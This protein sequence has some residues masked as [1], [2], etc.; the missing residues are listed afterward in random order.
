MRIRPPLLAALTALATAIGSAA[1]YLYLNDWFGVGDLRAM[2]VWSMPVAAG[3]YLASHLA[4]R[5]SNTGFRYLAAVLLGLGIGLVWDVGA[6]AV[7]GGW[8]F[9]FSFPVFFCWIAASMVGLIVAVWAES[10]RTWAVAVAL[11]ALTG[12]GTARS[13]RHAQEPPPRVVVYLKPGITEAE[14]ATVW[15]DVLG[16]SHPGRIGH[17]LKEPIASVLRDVRS[18]EVVLVV[19]FW[20]GHAAARNR[21]L[22]QVAR[23]ALVAR[24][25]PMD[26]SEPAK[27][28]RSVEY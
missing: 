14:I 15:T 27:V 8:I 17:D 22:G 21:L 20:K 2:I 24:I 9:A 10:P 3:V 28:R 19:D 26:P 23:S 11:L 13:F 25:V 18:G 4:L 5:P 12:L 7:L 6:A 1:V 16:E